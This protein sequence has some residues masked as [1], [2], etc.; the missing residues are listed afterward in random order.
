MKVQIFDYEGKNI[1]DTGVPGELVCSRPHP[2]MPV[3]F[4]NDKD[5]V[6]YRKAYFET[7]PGVWHH[8]DFM[9]KNP[10]T[11]G[12]IILGRRCAPCHT[13]KPVR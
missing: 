8:G 13:L 10:Q 1:E 12:F 3:Y 7:F 6:K 4:W 2:S 5:D 11:K 9:V